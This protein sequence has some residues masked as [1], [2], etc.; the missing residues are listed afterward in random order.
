MTGQREVGRHS[1]VRSGETLLNS[2]AAMYLVA[3]Q[4]ILAA[5]V[6]PL[7]PRKLSCESFVVELRKS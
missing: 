7:V 4:R 2:T 5:L 1:P 6:S 3:R